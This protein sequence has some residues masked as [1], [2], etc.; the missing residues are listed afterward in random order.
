[1]DL[2]L[3]KLKPLL[4]A[5]YRMGSEKYGWSLNGLRMEYRYGHLP[6]HKSIHMKKWCSL[7]KLAN[8]CL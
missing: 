6:E 7:L 3:E 8:K 2:C 5:S 4:K 1:M